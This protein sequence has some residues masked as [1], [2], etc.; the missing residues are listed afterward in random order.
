[1]SKGV[2]GDIGAMVKG[3]DAIADAAEQIRRRQA[4]TEDAVSGLEAS[5]SSEARVRFQGVMDH[6]HQDMSQV[7]NQL[8]QIERE[9]E[10]TITAYRSQ[11][12]NV[13]A[14]VSLPTS[15]QTNPI[16]SVLSGRPGK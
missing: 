2:K 6:W 9:L 16:G 15:G 4:A 7:L 13:S 1:M 11:Q 8:G 3:K 14:A 10:T 5:W 12:A